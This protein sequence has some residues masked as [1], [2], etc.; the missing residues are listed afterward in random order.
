V[1]NSR[2]QRFSKVKKNGWY[3]HENQ[4]T[5]GSAEAVYVKDSPST[6]YIPRHLDIQILNSLIICCIF[7][8]V[9]RFAQLFLGKFRIEI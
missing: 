9:A 8:F 5:L 4:V 1:K 2:M 7:G 3:F 6:R